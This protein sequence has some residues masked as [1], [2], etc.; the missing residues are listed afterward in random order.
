M[1]EIDG[2]EMVCGKLRHKEFDLHRCLT[3]RGLV[4]RW[5]LSYWIESYVFK[6]DP[7][8]QFARFEPMFPIGIGNGRFNQE[9]DGP[10][11][12]ASS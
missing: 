7:R 4:S 12:K 2:F 1:F 8:H 10:T 5:S 9:K 3:L 11:F 6:S